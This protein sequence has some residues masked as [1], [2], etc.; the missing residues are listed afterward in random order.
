[1]IHL[2]ASVKLPRLQKAPADLSLD[3]VVFKMGLFPCNSCSSKGKG[4]HWEGIACAGRVRRGCLQPE[5]KI[6][7]IVFSLHDVKYYQV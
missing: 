5:L 4:R 7:V 1:M 3:Y 2:E 6:I